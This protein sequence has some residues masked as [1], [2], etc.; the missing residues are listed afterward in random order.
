M[1]IQATAD[2]DAQ[3]GAISP[4]NESGYG[5]VNAYQMLLYQD[6]VGIAKTNSLE[7]LVYPNPSTGNF[8]VELANQ[9]VEKG[10][11]ITVFEI[12]GQLVLESNFTQNK[13]EFN[14]D[15]VGVYIVKI[16]DSKGNLFYNKL[17]VQ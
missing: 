4:N 16:E 6:P 15:P 11:S 7:A 5:R 17:I 1:G 8:T 3:T 2:Q 13:F 12:G 9:V 14:L 10:I